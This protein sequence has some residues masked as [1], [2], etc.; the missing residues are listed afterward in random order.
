MVDLGIDGGGTVYLTAYSRRPATIWKSAP[1]W[2][3]ANG[4]IQRQRAARP[5]SQK[6]LFQFAFGTSPDIRKRCDLSKRS[7]NFIEA[8]STAEGSE[9]C[10]ANVAGS[11]ESLLTELVLTANLEK[12]LEEEVRR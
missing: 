7:G 9:V 10:R 12:L 5:R 6:E 11:A 4:A 8:G 3:I 2:K 1:F